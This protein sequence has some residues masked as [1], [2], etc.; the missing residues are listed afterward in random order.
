VMELSPK[1]RDEKDE[2]VAGSELPAHAPHSTAMVERDPGATPA[3]NDASTVRI[4]WRDMKVKIG[5]PFAGK[6]VQWS[7]TAQ[8][9]P[10]QENGDPEE[11]ARMR[12]DWNQAENSE[13]RYNFSVSEKY[14]ASDHHFARG[15]G[16]DVDQTATTSVDLAGY[17]AIRVNFPPIGF[18]KARIAL[19]IDPTGLNIPADLID[20]EVP[21]IVVIDPG[22]GGPDPGN[23][24]ETVTPKLYE[25][26]LALLYATE[27]KTNLQK[28]I[29]DQGR[30]CKVLVGKQH[31][32][33]GTKYENGLR[34]FQARDQGADINLS[35][36]FNGGPESASGTQVYVI[37]E[38]QGNVNHAQDLA[39]ATR[40]YTAGEA[41]FGVGNRSAEQRII[42]L[43]PG[44]NGHVFLRDNLLNNIAGP[45]RESTFI[46]AT[47]LELE[48][49]T[50]AGMA[51]KLTGPNATTT[52][53][54][55]GV[56]G[57]QA[58][59]N[60]LLTQP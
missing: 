33:N 27:L 53:Q 24:I 56:Q 34:A 21:A 50:V 26:D 37:R 16:T 57:A 54:D 39:L 49:L 6:T 7:M 3:L 48:Y 12:G 30:S 52:M 17:T 14:E 11:A 40:M 43:E 31:N 45:G 55:Y 46:R 15:S 38:D 44:A 47:L 13:Y 10:T 29:R 18:N 23:S 35:L 19:V 20:L 5:V 22:H 59:I 2:I 41:V 4:A 28:N 25:R 1:L 58:V 9:T 51:D 60:D 32:P 42:D 8:F 36:H